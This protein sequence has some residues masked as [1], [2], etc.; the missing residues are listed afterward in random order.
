MKIASRANNEIINS[1]T[2]F[3]PAP[4]ART[5]LEKMNKFQNKKVIPAKT[6]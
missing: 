2:E 3:N 4:I 6:Q 5:T 1:K